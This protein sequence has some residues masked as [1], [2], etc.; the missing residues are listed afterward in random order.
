MMVT[1][2]SGSLARGNGKVHLELEGFTGKL[3]QGG[4]LE[5]ER[6]ASLRRSKEVASE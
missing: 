3:S 6:E 1:V 4:L 5:A 2:P